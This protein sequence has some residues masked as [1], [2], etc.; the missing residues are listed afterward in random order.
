MCIRDRS[1]DNSFR[2]QVEKFQRNLERVIYAFIS[3]MHISAKKEITNE[4]IVEKVLYYVLA[5]SENYHTESRIYNTY[6]NEKGEK[7]SGR[8]DLHLTR[9]NFSVIVELKYGE[10][11][12]IA[13]T[14]IFS[15]KY[16]TIYNNTDFSSFNIENE[17]FLGINVN[18]QGDVGYLFPIWPTAEIFQML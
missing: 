8:L 12:M 4:S 2:R 16:Y 18:K 10:N 7:K 17:I 13:L 14:Q 5:Y 1:S 15:N 3:F 11:S 6:I 9:G